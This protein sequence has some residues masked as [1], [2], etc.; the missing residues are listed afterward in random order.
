VLGADGDCL[1]RDE[2][3]IASLLKAHGYRTGMIGKWHLGLQIPGTKGKRDW[4]QAVTD[5]PLQKGFDSFY[6]IPASMN[7]G[8]LTWFDNDRAMAPASMWTRKKFPKSEI[9][10]KPRD[11]RMAPPFDVAPRGRRDIEVA[12]DFADVDVLRIIAGRSVAFLEDAARHPEQPFFLY[13][14]FT[15]P[16]LPHC[17]APEFRG[18]SGMGNYGDFMMETDARVGQ[19]LAALDRHDLASDTLV[20]FSSDNGP[21]NNWRD[22]LRIYDHRCSGGF[23]GG[24][25]DVYEGGHRVPFLLRWPGV[26]AP[27]RVDATPV[28]QTDLLATFAEILGAE[29]PDDAGVD[30]F[31]FLPRLRGE[32]MRA[33]VPM[34]HH[35]G[36]GKFA[37]RSGRYKLIFYRPGRRGAGS[38]QPGQPRFEI[39]DLEADAAET[40]NIVAE[41]PAVVA[42]LQAEATAIVQNGRSTP[43]PR[44]ANDGPAW[45]R[46]LSWIPQPK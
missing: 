30:S 10:A 8:V 15:S 17:T 38:A 39:Y 9:Q 19:I 28:C 36:N 3:T 16:H 45:W 20:V 32:S 22:W 7:Y 44:C 26:I 29:L 11:Y 1:I 12:A 2:M 33:R 31:S 14:P 37:I 4:N 5:G 43:G 42:R 40:R 34:I 23:R 6:G 41:H 18:K 27:G 21:E 35:A 24:K 25:R 46:Q 13:V